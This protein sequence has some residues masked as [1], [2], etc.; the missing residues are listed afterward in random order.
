MNPFNAATVHLDILEVL[1]AEDVSSMRTDALAA[2][3]SSLIQDQ[4]NQ[5][6][7]KV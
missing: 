1:S 5:V 4:L 6:E 7:Q 2:H 3:A